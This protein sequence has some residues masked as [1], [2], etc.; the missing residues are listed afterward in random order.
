M[1]MIH[2]SGRVGCQ[3]YPKHDLVYKYVKLSKDTFIMC[4]WMC[5]HGTALDIS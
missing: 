5:Q 2:S 3:E 1:M 4:I